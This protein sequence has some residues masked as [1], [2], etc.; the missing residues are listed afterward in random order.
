MFPHGIGLNVAVKV[1]FYLELP[2][3]PDTFRYQIS[4]HPLS[5]NA[6]DRRSKS[7]PEP[8]SSGADVEEH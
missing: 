3:F 5:K 6:C 7:F 2:G 1:S 8:R 4:H